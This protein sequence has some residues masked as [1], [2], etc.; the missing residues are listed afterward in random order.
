[1]YFKKNFC[2]IFFLFFGIIVNAKTVNLDTISVLNVVDKVVKW[3]LEHYDDMDKNRI[4]KSFG[5]LSW[6]NG[7]FLSALS[8]WAEYRKDST[9]IE[10]YRNICKRNRYSLSTANH[11]IYHADDLAVCLMYATLYDKTNNDEVI[12]HTLSRLEFIMNH[13]SEAVF[14]KKSKHM[15]DRWCW[16]DALYMAPP[17]FARF[18]NITGND[19]MRDFMD[20]EYWDTYDFLYDKSDSLFYRDAKYF[21]RKENNGEKVFWGRGNAWVLA[22]LSR[23]ISYLPYDYPSRD[24]YVS[25][26]KE[27]VSRIVTLQD[28][29]GY[30]HA[31]MLDPSSYPDP[32]MSCTTFFTYS[33][34]W[35]INNGILDKKVYLN[36]AING[37]RAI[38][39]CVQ[40]NGMLGW[41]QP[42]GQDPK[43][44]TAEMTEVYGP[45]AVM[46]A[47]MEILKY[48]D[49]IHNLDL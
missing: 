7:V 26:F 49:D 23:I 44:V 22:G 25:L 28:K 30:W 3:Q 29:H 1:M 48:I 39:N 14:G 19:R 17:V 2:T 37:W 10:W 18:A 24:K 33:L 40:P 27:M 35:G 9:M 34:W 47:A 21:K 4:Y 13:P 38:E 5:D 41:V 8:E 45:A 16:C 15:N 11:R 12:H 20:K 42:V 43:K 46:L 36:Y 32:E 31:S 6:E